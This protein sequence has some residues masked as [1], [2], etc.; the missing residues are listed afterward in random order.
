MKCVHFT[1][2]LLGEDRSEPGFGSPCTPPQG[3][4]DARSVPSKFVLQ[5]ARR[6]VS[7]VSTRR[8]EYWSMVRLKAPS[9]FVFGLKLEMYTPP[10]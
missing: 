5:I 6:Y 4:L 9:A 10:M 7:E 2:R 3:L 1:T 8:P